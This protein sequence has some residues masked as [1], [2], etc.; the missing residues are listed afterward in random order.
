M[1]RK[2]FEPSAPAVAE[3]HAEGDRWTLVFER[4]LPHPPEKVWAAL[5]EVAQLREWA[6]FVAD[7]NLD[8]PGG[9]T[10]TMVDGDV[11]EEMPATVRRVERPRLLEYTWG[12]DVLCWQLSPSGPGTRL[13]LRHTLADEDWVPK[14]A[15]GWHLCLDVADRLIA[16][17]P[18]GPIRGEEAMDYGWERLRDAY[19]ERLGLAPGNM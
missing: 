17:D 18:V 9:A 13:T 3:Y 8:A 2:S 6:P 15:A 11:A 14:V 16:E 12:E 4:D 7:R 1:N 19:A 5:T 10:L